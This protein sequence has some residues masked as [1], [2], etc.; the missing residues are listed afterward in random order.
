MRIG[1]EFG[2]CEGMDEGLN[3]IFD[4]GRSLILDRTRVEFKL[5]G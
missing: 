4:F 3:V 2:A 1:C 5:D